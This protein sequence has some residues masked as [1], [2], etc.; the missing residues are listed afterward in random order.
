MAGI[1]DVL[2]FGEQ[3]I[4][5]PVRRLLGMQK[6]VE[7]PSELPPELRQSVPKW[8][9]NATDNLDKL[10]QI[11]PL[12]SVPRSTIP[13]DLPKSIRAYRDDSSGR[14][15]GKY[16]LETLP[17]SRFFV[18]GDE[19]H[20]KEVDVSKSTTFNDSSKAIQEIYRLARLNG[21]ASKYKYPNLS[22]EDIG[23]LILKEGR[24]DMGLNGTFSPG[25]EHPQD[26]KFYNEEL[27]KYT[28][29]PRDSAFLA[30]IYSKQRIAN[31]L[32][33][34]FA[35]AWNGTGVNDFGQSG[36]NYAKDYENHKR[37]I[38][39]EKNKE[40]LAIIKRG[41]ADGE[42]YGLPLRSN[43]KNDTYPT[44]KKVDYSI[45]GNVHMP[46]NYSN[47]NWKLI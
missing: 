19:V 5:N 18:G 7:V 33:I 34:P 23:A 38:N 14:Y 21:A 1:E 3:N 39:H 11:N 42:K 16:G 37:A 24:S 47:G 41:I 10:Q 26:A 46:D 12:F 31:K 2:H 6:T 20:P 28:M 43:V 30:N 25:L 45:G 9:N 35:M 32:N 13:E 27:S 40:L 29:H 44:T 15:G 22:A 8:D 36:S 4:L 17:I